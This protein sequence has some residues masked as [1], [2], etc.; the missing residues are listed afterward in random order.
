[1]AVAV[2]PCKTWLFGVF[3][4]VCSVYDPPLERS[5]SLLTGLL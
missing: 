5:D 3:F 2:N 4:S 1:M